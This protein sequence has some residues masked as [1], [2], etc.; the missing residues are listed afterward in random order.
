[1]WLCGHEHTLV[2]V[3]EGAGILVLS[4]FIFCDFLKGTLYS[5]QNSWDMAN[6][7]PLSC[8]PRVFLALSCLSYK[9]NFKCYAFLEVPDGL[10]HSFFEFP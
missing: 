6:I 2:C 7:L 3:W 9:T 8:L 5:N 4:D 10:D 1:M